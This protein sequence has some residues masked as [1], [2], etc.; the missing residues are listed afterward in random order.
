MSIEKK[1]RPKISI[2]FSDSPKVALTT[3]YTIPQDTDSFKDRKHLLTLNN[4]FNA[5]NKPE[6]HLKGLLFDWNSKEWPRFDNFM[7]RCVQLFLSEGLTA[8]DSADLK[9]QKLINIT[10]QEFFNLMESDYDVLNE[11][12]SIKEIAA[13]VD[14]PTKDPRARGGYVS[15]W[16]KSYAAFK[17]YKVEKIKSGGI[18]K[19][20]FVEA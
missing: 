17:G 15:K 16:I 19:I 13:S 20:C 3:N 6:K 5:S 18:T 8:Y 2:A 12:H 7:I 4:F 1:H 9:K 14:V 10:S 11:Y